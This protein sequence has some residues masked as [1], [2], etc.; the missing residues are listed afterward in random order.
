MSEIDT[1]LAGEPV[2]RSPS[3]IRSSAARLASDVAV[4][5][6]G[7]VFA[8]LTARWLGIDGK[9]VLAAI[10]LWTAILFQLASFGITEAAIVRVGQGAVTAQHALSATLAPLL[11]LAACGAA[12]LLGTLA[13]QVGFGRANGPA[14]AAVVAGTLVLSV[15]A[16]LGACLL[17]AGERIATSSAIGVA[18]QAVT[19]LVFIGFGIAGRAS[20]L[21]AVTAIAGG[22]L[23]SAVAA[24]WALRRDGLHL[25][26][27]WDPTY[28][29]SALRYGVRAQPAI[30][31]TSA[32]A[33]L[34]LAVLYALSGSGDAGVYSVALT[35]GTL[36]SAV[37]FAVSHAMFP[38]LAR[39]DASEARNLVTRTLRLVVL[40]SVA[41]S[42]PMAIAAGPVLAAVFGNE[43]RQGAAAAAILVFAAIPW[44]VQWVAARAEGA[45]DRPTVLLWTFVANAVVT[46][47][48]DFVLVPAHGPVAAAG[49]S[50]LG[51]VVGALLALRASA[52]PI[53]AL[54]PRRGDPSEL[55][56]SLRHALV[57]TR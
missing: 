16:S 11:P 6:I 43:Y 22:A 33:R 40:S 5:A 23:T 45:R 52:I 17:I 39:L 28:L 41:L 37:A 3:L 47:T 27:R 32:A 25:R 46:L 55:L 44:S 21:S 42:I 13:L 4:L 8:S 56:T 24:W 7:T 9:G 30:I 1:S 34:D 10:T 51:N 54:V 36:V 29:R 48:A 15:I 2:V 26:P 19:L 35:Y 38:R 57:P 12:V 50:L 20:L 14:I 53:T 31:A 18:A 49:A